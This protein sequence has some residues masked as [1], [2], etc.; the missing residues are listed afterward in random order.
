MNY[1]THPHFATPNHLVLKQPNTIPIVW[2]PSPSKWLAAKLPRMALRPKDT[3]PQGVTVTLRQ[4]SKNVGP[5][6]VLV[7]LLDL[8]RY[9]DWR[10]EVLLIFLGVPCVNRYSHY[11]SAQHILRAQH[12]PWWLCSQPPRNRSIP[13]H[14]ALVDWTRCHRDGNEERNPWHHRNPFCLRFFLSVLEEWSGVKLPATHLLLGWWT[15]YLQSL[16]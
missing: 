14:V 5:S 4:H 10:S 15:L 13:R 7:N 9:F 6:E 3:H 2:P 16:V 8:F 11:G 1:P 12:W